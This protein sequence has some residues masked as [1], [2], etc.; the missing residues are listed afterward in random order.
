MDLIKVISEDLKL[1][2][3][4]LHTVTEDYIVTTNVRIEV[5]SAFELFE[6][7]RIIEQVPGVEE[8]RMQ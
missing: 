1:S 8:V 6:A 4:S 3:D 2:I 7:V 5:P